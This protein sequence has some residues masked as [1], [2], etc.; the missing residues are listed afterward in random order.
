M[1]YRCASSCHLMVVIENG[2]WSWIMGSRSA[3]CSWCGLNCVSHPWSMFY[4]PH[5]NNESVH[6]LHSRELEN[7]ALVRSAS[8]C[9]DP[10]RTKQRREVRYSGPEIWPSGCRLTLPPRQRGQGYCRRD[11]GFSIVAIQT[12]DTLTIH[13]TVYCRQKNR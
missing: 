3:C 5:L 9:S 4:S 11:S 8:G 7:T 1:P 10:W 12:P 13:H 2:Y 6:F